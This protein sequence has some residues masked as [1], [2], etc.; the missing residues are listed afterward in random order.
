MPLV[1]VVSSFCDLSVGDVVYSATLT[2][3]DGPD[4][5]VRVN[6]NQRGTRGF[7]TMSHKVQLVYAQGQWRV[8]RTLER[9]H[10]AGKCVEH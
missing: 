5:E 9:I 3:L 4:A 6:Y 1:G 7:G 10:F 2:K 8:S